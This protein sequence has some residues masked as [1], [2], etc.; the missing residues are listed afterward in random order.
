MTPR[1]TLIV[2]AVIV[3]A[4][5]AWFALRIYR[6]AYGTGAPVEITVANYGTAVVSDI[7]ITHRHGGLEYI[8]Q[9]APGEHVER[10]M[11]ASRGSSVRISYLD[12]Q[13][14]LKVA[15]LDVYVGAMHP[16]QLVVGFQDDGVVVK[17]VTGN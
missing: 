5:T 12:A 16:S 8:P 4:L 9:L 10:T 14:Q 3:I 17:E 6:G 7:H 13:R 11:H 2:L 15:E 1:R